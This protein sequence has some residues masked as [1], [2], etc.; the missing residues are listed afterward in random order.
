MTKQAQGASQRSIELALTA[1]EALDEKKGEDILILDVSGLLVVTDVFLLA[2]GT[3]TRH[4]RSLM[5]DAEIA[6]REVDRRPIRREG[7]EYGEWVLLDYG[8]VVIHVFESETRGYY[9]L[10]RL[11]A[12]A[13]QIP[14]ASRAPESD[15]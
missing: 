13:P 4:V 5:D 10:E 7:A 1:A 9:D 12:D 2:S 15:S 14:F 3:S 11:W 6:L 8:D